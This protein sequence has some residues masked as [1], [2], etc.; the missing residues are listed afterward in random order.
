M[1]KFIILALIFNLAFNVFA[2][3]DTMYVYNKGTVIRI[4]VQNID[5]ITFEY[6]VP[7]VFICGT[8]TVLDV[9]SNV[10]NTVL[11]GNQCWLKENLRVT[12][13]SDGETITG[14]PTAGTMVETRDGAL[15]FYDANHSTVNTNPPY[16]LF[17]NWA[18]AARA[19]DCN[20]NANFSDEKRQGVC[21]MGWH[22]PSRNEWKVLEDYLG[23]SNIAGGKMKSLGT[24]YWTTP[25]AGAATES[26]SGFSALPAG[27]HYN[28]IVEMSQSAYFWS[29]TQNYPDAF[30][31]QLTYFFPFMP[32]GNYQKHFGHSVRCVKD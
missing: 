32:S 8:S 15:Y 10:Y 22:L 19:T 4:P 16:G 9:D 23:G 5:S 6:R 17:Y 7:G 21:P 12:R 18:A 25:N 3:L 26:S 20:S 29:S 14:K 2:Q 1:K 31:I 13:Y 27:K 28:G 24:A 30:A 11:I